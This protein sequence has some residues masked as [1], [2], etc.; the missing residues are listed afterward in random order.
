MTTH[1][2]SGSAITVTAVQPP[3]RFGALEIDVDGVITSFRKSLMVMAIGS[4]VVFLIDKPVLDLIDNDDSIW[5][6][7][8]LPAL[9]KSGN[10][11]AQSILVSGN[12]WILSVTK[13]T[14]RV[15]GTITRH[16][17]K[18]GNNVKYFLGR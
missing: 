4:M 17:G 13:I 14:Y 5:E 9:A 1:P 10:L 11:H 8:V 3:G 12:L 7:D 16:H 18:F 6:Q 15:F 2:K